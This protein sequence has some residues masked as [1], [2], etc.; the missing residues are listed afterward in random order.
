M[1]EVMAEERGEKY[2][3]PQDAAV[4]DFARDSFK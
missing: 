2:V 3:S 1:G 4:T